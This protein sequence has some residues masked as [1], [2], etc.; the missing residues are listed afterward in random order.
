MLSTWQWNE[1]AIHVFYWKRRKKQ[2]KKQKA[3][4]QS[5]KKIHKV[6]AVRK[7]LSSTFT[8]TELIYNDAKLI[9]VANYETIN[10]A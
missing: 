10:A 5:Q 8:W 7:A 3:L 6:E 4:E 1:I 2:N 9:P